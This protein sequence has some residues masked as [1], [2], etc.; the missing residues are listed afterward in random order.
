MRLYIVQFAK[1][2]SLKLSIT[3]DV[4]FGVTWGMI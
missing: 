1:R 2:I 4:T 3:G